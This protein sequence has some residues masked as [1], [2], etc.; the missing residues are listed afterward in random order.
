MW[1]K[2]RCE[3]RDGFLY[4]SH[5]DVCII[6]KFI[7]ISIKIFVKLFY[8]TRPW[9]IKVI[10]SVPGRVYR[11]LKRVNWAL[12]INRQ[13]Y[14]KIISYDKKKNSESKVFVALPL[15]CH[16]DMPL[17]LNIWEKYWKLEKLNV[18]LL[19]IITF[20]NICI[21]IYISHALGY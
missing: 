20:S 19:Y 5:S 9:I 7:L 15:W 8:H 3:I 2:R 14:L 18:L 10:I 6:I 4:I 12:G 17:I 16:D 21:H 13:C 1:Q 11:T